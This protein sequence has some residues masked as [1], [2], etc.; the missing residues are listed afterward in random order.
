MKKRYEKNSSNKHCAGFSLVADAQNRNNNNTADSPHKGI[1][2]SVFGGSVF[3]NVKGKVE[4]VGNTSIRGSILH[5]MM[6]IG[7]AYND[8]AFG[9]AFSTNS[10]SMKTISVGDSTYTALPGWSIDNSLTGLYIKKYFMPLNIF[11]SAEA[12]IGKFTISD[13]DYNAVTETEKGFAWNVAAGKE[14]LIGKKKRWG[15]GA[16]VNV[17]GIKC[18]DV[19]P[20]QN[21]S[22]SLLAPGVGVVASLH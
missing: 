16:Y 11:V 19:P 3:G 10:L 22:Y 7:Y 21:D 8:W 4:S 9:F 18:N 13:P 1:Q 5:M 20:W 14:F 12:G 6:H 2:V 17:C 15:L